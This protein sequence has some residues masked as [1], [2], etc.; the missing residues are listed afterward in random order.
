MFEQKRFQ[1]YFWFLK[2]DIFKMSKIEKLKK[3]LKKGCFSDF[4]A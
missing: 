2:M 3:V 4:R 1:K